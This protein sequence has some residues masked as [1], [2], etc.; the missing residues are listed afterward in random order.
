MIWKDLPR[1]AHK[2][3]R[4]SVEMMYDLGFN[5]TFHYTSMTGRAEVLPFDLELLLRIYDA[6]PSSCAWNKTAPSEAVDLIYGDLI[7]PYKGD[8]GAEAAVEM[9]LGQRLTAILDRSVTVLYRWLTKEGASSR[10][11]TMILTKIKAMGSTPQER[12]N[13]FESIA[14][15]AWR[16]RG[17]DI[18][19]TFEFN[20]E[21]IVSRHMATGVRDRIL[22]RSPGK[23]EVGAGSFG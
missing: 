8:L 19:Q 18:E 7:A 1:F 20:A 5:T 21:A 22:H 23:Y 12:R 9:F 6:Y 2:H 4:A 15:P 11:I 13:A 16:L 17:V 3:G 14:L 10:R